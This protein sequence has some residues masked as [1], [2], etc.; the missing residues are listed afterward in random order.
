MGGQRLR[1]RGEQES[2]RTPIQEGTVGEVGRKP[3]EPLSIRAKE[4]EFKKECVI[5]GGKEVRTEDVPQTWQWGFHMGSVAIP[6]SA[7]RPPL[8]GPYPRE[9]AW[10]GETGVLFDLKSPPD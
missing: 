6:H 10:H 3:G 4:T 2:P 9:P 7:T 1:D 8:G 5:R